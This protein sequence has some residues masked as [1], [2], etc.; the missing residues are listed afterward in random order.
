MRNLASR[1][2]FRSKIRGITLAGKAHS[3]SA[4]FVLALRLMMGF[5]FLYS[6]VDKILAGRFDAQGYLVGAVPDAS[7]LVGLFATMGQTPWLVGFVNVAVPW[8]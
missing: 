3:L 7:P 5:A 2:L 1:P 4:W 6:G 8:G